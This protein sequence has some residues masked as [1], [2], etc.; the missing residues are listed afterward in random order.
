MDVKLGKETET[1]GLSE[2]ERK[3]DTLTENT[4]IFFYRS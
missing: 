1:A 3:N 4:K 2:T